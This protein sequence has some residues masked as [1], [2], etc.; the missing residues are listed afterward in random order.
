[1]GAAQRRDRMLARR[2]HGP[3]RVWI[4]IAAPQP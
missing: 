1:V 4:N 2:Q 3:R